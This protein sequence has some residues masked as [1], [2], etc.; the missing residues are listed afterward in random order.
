VRGRPCCAVLQRVSRPLAAAP[1]AEAS[2]MGGPCGMPMSNSTFQL[3]LHPRHR[4]AGTH[5]R[6]PGTIHTSLFAPI[7]RLFGHCHFSGGRPLLLS[8]PLP[9]IPHLN[10][11]PTPVVRCASADDLTPEDAN[12]RYRAYL[13]EYHGS[14]IKAEFMQTRNEER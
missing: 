8:Q 7:S 13:V 14:E 10:P 2:P 3:D 11:A 1:V 9:P 6:I 12:A 4:H 5:P